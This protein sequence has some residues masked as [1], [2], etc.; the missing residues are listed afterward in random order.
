V[1]TV[2]E[3]LR[4]VRRTL[5]RVTSPCRT[6][7][8]GCHRSEI[9]VRSQGALGHEKALVRH[10]GE[11]SVH[12][13]ASHPGVASR[14]SGAGELPVGLDM[15]VAAF[16]RS[17]HIRHFV[18]PTGGPAPQEPHQAADRRHPDGNYCRPHQYPGQPKAP[19]YFYDPP[20]RM[21]KSAQLVHALRNAHDQ[22]YETGRH[23]RNT[24]VMGSSGYRRQERDVIAQRG[25]ALPL[26]LSPDAR[27]TA[28]ARPVLP[29][30][31]SGGAAP[32]S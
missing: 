8:A 14:G 2:A 10:F 16:M 17:R 12:R 21:P 26:R 18:A 5:P 4:A 23:A 3:T 20:L 30:R 15:H 6:D 25:G 22:F 9:A 11:V 7:C 1:C 29:A 28:R 19:L 13:R 24:R 27:R 32:T 31:L